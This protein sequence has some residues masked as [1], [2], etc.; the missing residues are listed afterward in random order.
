MKKLIKLVVISSLFSSMLVSAQPISG[1]S[2][3]AMERLCYVKKEDTSATYKSEAK[4]YGVSHHKLKKL[5]KNLKCNGVK[6]GEV[7]SQWAKRNN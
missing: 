2:K 5:E 7:E 3:S 6:L 4:R 1:V